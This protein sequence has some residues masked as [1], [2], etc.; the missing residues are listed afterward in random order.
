MDRH[1]SPVQFLVD[2]CEQVAVEADDVSMIQIRRQVFSHLEGL[3][4]MLD[5]RGVHLDPTSQAF[6]LGH[7]TQIPINV[8]DRAGRL[9]VTLIIFEELIAFFQSG[10]VI[11]NDF[12]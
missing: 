4:N 5:A 12:H 2:V 9:G 11:S 8:L 10:I 6:D 3:E 7:D 1:E